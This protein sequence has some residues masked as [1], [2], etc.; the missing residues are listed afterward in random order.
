MQ[1]KN[2]EFH[3]QLFKDLVEFSK[4]F[5]KQYDDLKSDLCSSDHSKAEPAIKTMLS[6]YP[7]DLVN[8]YG[9]FKQTTES[10]WYRETEKP[11]LNK[12][13]SYFD[14]IKNEFE[15]LKQA[16]KYLYKTD[17]QRQGYKKLSMSMGSRW[18]S[19]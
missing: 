6:L 17:N 7:S 9:K 18:G 5:N 11:T 10:K 12:I 3:I 16:Q 15:G 2:R 19:F 8:K 13:K 1:V 14:S 4:K